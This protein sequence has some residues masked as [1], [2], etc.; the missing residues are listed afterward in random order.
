M[1]NRFLLDRPL[2]DRLRTRTN[3]EIAWEALL[4]P[5]PALVNLLRLPWS[6]LFLRRRR[7]GSTR[8]FRRAGSVP[9]SASAGDDPS[10]LRRTSIRLRGIRLTRARCVPVYCTGTSPPQRL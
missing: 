6:L 5:R 8:C 7:S 2:Y 4:S 1:I 10:T 9:C 3:V